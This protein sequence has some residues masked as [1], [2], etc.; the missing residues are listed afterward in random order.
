MYASLS[1]ISRKCSSGVTCRTAALQAGAGPPSDSAYQEGA[2]YLH[3]LGMD[4]KGDIM[5]I[6]DVAMNPNSL[7]ARHRDRKRSTNASVSTSCILSNLML[8]KG[9]YFSQKMVQCTVSWSTVVV[10]QNTLEIDWFG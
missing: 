10:N 9:M 8:C 3:S 2:E 5:R 4:N 6:L 7:Y 1:P